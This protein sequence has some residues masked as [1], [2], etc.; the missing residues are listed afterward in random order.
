MLSMVQIITSKMNK[1]RLFIQRI[2]SIK[3]NNF[4]RNYGL[5]VYEPDYLTALKSPIPLY[6]C[7][8]VQIRGYDYT[9]VENC[10]KLL[11]HIA[12]SMDIEISDSWA[13]PPQSMQVTTFKPLS[14]I[15]DTQYKFQIYQR[16]LQM[17]DVTSSVLPVFLRLIKSS[18]PAGITVEVVNHEDFHEEIRYVPD[19]ELL[20]LKQQLEEMEGPPKKK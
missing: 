3:N 12:R 11:H 5:D 2:L 1:S 16:T 14:E 7:V 13:L 15:V 18:L 4:I 8:N 6:N 17:L 19:K 10:Q 9:V 20:D